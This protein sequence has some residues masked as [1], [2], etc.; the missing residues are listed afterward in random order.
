MNWTELTELH[1]ASKSANEQIKNAAQQVIDLNFGAWL[2][3][4]LALPDNRHETAAT[5]GVARWN[6]GEPRWKTIDDLAVAVL[7]WLR[8]N[9]GESNSDFFARMD[10]LK[11]DRLGIILRHRQHQRAR[12]ASTSPFD[13][14]RIRGDSYH[15]DLWPVR[16]LNQPVSEHEVI[17]A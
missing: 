5:V 16:D 6:K 17:L 8:Q 12:A 13:F 15:L 3:E 9:D 7:G 14:V 2:A 4:Y 1:E 11:S 10:R